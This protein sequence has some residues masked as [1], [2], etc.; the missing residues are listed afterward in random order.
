[1]NRMLLTQ[2]SAFQKRLR[3]LTKCYKKTA[4]E[5]EGRTAIASGV[6]LRPKA[7]GACETEHQR[8]N[9]GGQSL[10]HIPRVDDALPD[11]VADPKQKDDFQSK[12][13]NV[14]GS[15]VGL[16]IHGLDAD[17]VRRV[18]DASGA[19]EEAHGDVREHAA[20]AVV[21]GHFYVH[22]FGVFVGPNAESEVVQLLEVCG[23]AVAVAK[24]AAVASRLLV[25][26][27]QRGVVRGAEGTCVDFLRPIVTFHPLHVETVKR[28]NL[29]WLT[30]EMQSWAKD[31]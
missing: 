21:E 30:D 28:L 16:K 11:V 3:Y 13:H 19:E 10:E 22:G 24:E 25:V 2:S 1:M 17:H 5:G 26:L 23:H 12:S 20:H 18:E 14:L 7:C 9:S 31:S 29:T 8:Q 6:C 15:V 27:V 4:R